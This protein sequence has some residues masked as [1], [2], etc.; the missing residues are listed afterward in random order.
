MAVVDSLLRLLASQAAD[1]LVIPSGEP[2]SLERGGEPRPLSMPDPGPEFVAMVIAEVASP[3]ERTRLG[4]GSIIETTHVGG[5]GVRY[6]V[7]IE[8]RREG[9][10]IV[11]RTPGSASVETPAPTLAP[12]APT[13][14]R[15]APTIAP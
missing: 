11:F 8:P 13:I 1:A 12:P 7:R 4:A 15:A 5:D 9:P 3:E 2:P 10:R 6:G 14:P